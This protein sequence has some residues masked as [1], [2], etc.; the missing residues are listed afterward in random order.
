MALGRGMA[1]R[2]FTNLKRLF[3]IL[4][5]RVHGIVEVLLGYPRKGLETSPREPFR[6]PFNWKQTM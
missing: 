6:D 3:N 2:G 1:M 5:R 4:E